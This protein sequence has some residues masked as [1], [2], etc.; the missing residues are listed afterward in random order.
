MLAALDR[1]VATHGGRQLAI[2]QASPRPHQLA[3]ETG[4]ERDEDQQRA[5]EHEQTVE[6]VLVD[7]VVKERLL[8]LRLRRDRHPLALQDKRTRG[9]ASNL[10]STNT[11]RCH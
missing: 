1:R 11:I 10:L 9:I 3:D 5:E 7:D 2:S 8:E 4:V 6:D